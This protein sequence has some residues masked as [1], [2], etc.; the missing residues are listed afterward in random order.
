[1]AATLALRSAQQGKST[2]LLEVDAPDSA[3]RLLGFEPARDEPREVLDRLWV[4]NMSPEGAVREYALMVLR[5]RTLY[6]MVFENRL[7]K[8]LLRSI[9][10]LG[11]FTMAGKFWFHSQQ[12]SG[13]QPR[14]DRVILDAPATGHA[15]TFLSVSRIVADLTP[16][17]PMKSE[18]LKMA[19]MI[20]DPLQTCLHVVAR[21]EEMP[22]NEALE[23]ERAA[24]EKVGMRLGVGFVNRV[25]PEPLDPEVAQLLDSMSSRLPQHP[26]LRVARA[27][28]AR[29]RRAEAEV[30][31]LGSHSRLSWLQLPEL[32]PAPRGYRA[33]A[34]LI[35]Q[36]DS[37]VKKARRLGA[38]GG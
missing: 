23:L 13:G 5:F 3:T 2:L 4:C 27:R 14:F 16:P 29:Q 11:E 31:R 22:V 28:V 6:R 8:Y 24:Q 20:E 21:P 36:V 9:P 10:S 25:D 38:T 34:P 12:S 7:V 18:A 32:V 37:F 15:I 17:G 19:A 33:L 35:D 30:A 1:M 26:I